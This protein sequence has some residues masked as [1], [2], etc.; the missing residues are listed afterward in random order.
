MGQEGTTVLVKH[1]EAAF[2]V[3]DAEGV[4][5]MPTGGE[6]HV[7]N[8]VGARVWELIDGRRNVDEIIAL[9]H[10]E[11]DVGPAR[12]SSDVQAFIDVLIENAMVAPQA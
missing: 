11:F 3:Y 10:E 8:Q 6:V 7:L 5:V 12:A 9:V 4:V 2:R 1:P